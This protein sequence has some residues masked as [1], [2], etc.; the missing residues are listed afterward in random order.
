MALSELTV[1]CALSL[2]YS[3]AMRS[4]ASLVNAGCEEEEIEMKEEKEEKEEE[5]IEEEEE[6]EEEIKE[7][8]EE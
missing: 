1:S 2:V 3:V 7:E 4:H 6:E 8:E 5:E